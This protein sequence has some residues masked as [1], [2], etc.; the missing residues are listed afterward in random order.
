MVAGCFRD[1]PGSQLKLQL[2][3][4]QID[5]GVILSLRACFL[6]FKQGYT[7]ILR[8]STAE[9]GNH[10]SLSL[11]HVPHTKLDLFHISHLTLTTG[12]VLLVPSYK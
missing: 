7:N 6:P 8:G 2:D 3:L 10:Y 1:L 5:Q 4:I 11:Y 9:M 12:Y